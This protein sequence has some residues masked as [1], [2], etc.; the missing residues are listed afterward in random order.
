MIWR[1]HM[2]NDFNDK[3]T[4]RQTV[5]FGNY[6]YTD[7]GSCKP[8]EWRILERTEDAIKIIT[9]YAID[10]CTFDD[11][12]AQNWEESSMCSWLNTTFYEKAFTDEEKKMIITANEKQYVFTQNDKQHYK[13]LILSDKEVGQLPTATTI[14]VPTPYAIQKGAPY[15]GEDSCDIAD[16]T[17]NGTEWWTRSFSNREV[18]LAYVV[19]VNG[20]LNRKGYDI[21][22]NKGIRPVMW[23]S[24]KKL[25]SFDEEAIGID[26]TYGWFA[27]DDVVTYCDDQYKYDSEIFIPSRINGKEIKTINPFVLVGTGQL[28]DEHGHWDGE[29]CI[30]KKNNSTTVIHVSD[31][32][33]ECNGFHGCEALREVYFPESL[34]R[35]AEGAFQ[36]CFS[37]QKVHMPSSMVTLGRWSFNFCRSLTDIS[38]PE[39]IVEIPDSAFCRCD[40]LRRIQIPSTVKTIGRYAFAECKALQFVKLPEGLETIGECAFMGDINLNCLMIP[41]SVKLIDETA[42]DLQNDYVGNKHINRKLMHSITLQCYPHSYALSFARKNLMKVENADNCV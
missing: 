27:K 12:F 23:L 40:S 5:N 3:E 25:L 37:L 31:G 1:L 16:P 33:V 38:L 24:L 34:E 35:L 2:K 8:I 19:N 41:K 18:G 36:F 29:Y 11:G 14:S 39:G 6:Y 21:S 26:Y 22:E 9:K 7:S 20:M 17:W 30:H 28:R 32:I 10:Y 13:I 4:Y 15:D 42:F